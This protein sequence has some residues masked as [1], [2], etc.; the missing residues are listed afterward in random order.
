MISQIPA[1]RVSSAGLLAALVLAA[2]TPWNASGQEAAEPVIPA[3]QATK[4]IVSM[5]V[6]FV[7]AQSLDEAR[8]RAQMSLREGEDYSDDRVERDIRSLFATGAIDDVSI[9]GNDVSGGVAV[10]VT[11]IGRGAIGSISFN[12]NRVFEDPRLRREIELKTGD[13]VDDRKLAEAQGKIRELYQKRGFADTLVTYSTQPDTQE[14]FTAVVFNIVEGSR[15]IIDD[16]RFEGNNSIKSSKLR[17]ALKSKR[18]TF[19]RL[20][21]KAG[22]LDNELLTQD[23]VAVEQAYQDEGFVYAKVVEVRREPVRGQRVAL[24]FVINEG[25]KYD[26]GTVA[27]EGVTIFSMGELTPGIATES[28]LPFSGKLVRA[29]EKMIRDYY[30][31][32]GYADTRV[33][34]SILSGGPGVVNILYRV[35]EGPKSFLRKINISGNTVTQ[36]RVIRRELPF[37]PGEEMNTVRMEAGKNRLENMNYFSQVDMRPAETGTPGLKDINLDVVEQSTGTINFGAGFSSIDSLVGFIDLT[38]TN[39]DITDWPTFRGAGQRFNMNARIGLQ[40]RDFNMSL[41]EPWFLGQKLA[42]TTALFYRN[43]FFLSDDFDQTD[44]GASLGLRK[45]LTEH[46]YIDLTYTIQNVNIGDISERASDIIRSE[47]GDYLQ[48][49]MDLTFVHD[50]RDNL[51]ITRKGHKFEAGIMGS[52]S[53]L[54]GDV[55][56]WGLNLAGM[57]F[58]HLP[59]D[60]ILS[61]EGAFRSVD[62][63]GSGNGV[64]IFERLF[65]GGANNLRGFDFRDVGPRD[66]NGEPIGGGTSAYLTAEFTFPLFSKVRGATFYDVGFVNADSFDLSTANVNSNVGVGLRLFLPIG[67]IRV[68]FGIPVQSDEFNDSNGRFQ[69]NIGYKF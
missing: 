32:R 41:T 8:V 14:G 13:V 69:F 37:L 52:G 56:V 15:G 64:P 19:W 28:G 12:G 44:A 39:F 53:A 65:L 54:G 49:K 57:Q 17:D 62:T 21:G 2:A 36:D 60:T 45:P 4:K 58:F 30:G 40:R 6:R 9:E 67:P 24:V 18:K 43:L 63:W 1:T 29:D 31:S 5:T 22:K 35:V 16:I 47:A 55:D 46:A 26:V 10:V 23:I 50:N 25:E 66:I 27:V 11:V 68:D 20:W 33:E 3:A 48:S 7:G 42:F 61:F 38:Q 59:G 34:T 51:F